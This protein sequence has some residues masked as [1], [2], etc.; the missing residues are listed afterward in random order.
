MHSGCLPHRCPISSPGAPEQ[1]T[2]PPVTDCSHTRVDPVSS[3]PVDSCPQCDITGNENADVLAKEGAQKEQSEDSVSYSE[4]KVLIMS[5][6]RTRSDRGDYY[7]LPRE[8]QV[9]LIRLHTGH[10]RLNAH[11]NRK[12]RMA[13]SP[14]YACS[15]EDQTAEHVLQRCTFHSDNWQKIWPHTHP[16]ADQ[17]EGCQEHMY[18]G[19]NYEE[20]GGGGRMEDG[21]KDNDEYDDYDDYEDDVNILLKLFC[22]TLWLVT[23]SY[24]P[25]Y[26]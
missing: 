1:Q 20:G 12:F 10:N 6:T 22:P 7:L 14:T 8:H 13:P 26:M 15:Q 16:I 19:E 11:M 5:L 21:D 25:W 23:S 9:I 4:Q 18:D 17:T 24:K 3:S 2:T